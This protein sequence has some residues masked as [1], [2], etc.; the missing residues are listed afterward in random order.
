MGRLSQS[1]KLLAR[2]RDRRKHER[3]R[4]RAA[5]EP[6]LAGLALRFL[7]KLVAAHRR[8]RGEALMR[9]CVG[10]GELEEVH[11]QGHGARP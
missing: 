10:A 1:R 2:E 3:D 5:Q 9:G 4:L 6:R 8:Q 11:P 7:R